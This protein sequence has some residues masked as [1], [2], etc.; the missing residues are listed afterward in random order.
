MDTLFV[1][2]NT[3]KSSRGYTYFQLSVA[4]KGFLYVVPIKKNVKWLRLWINS[5]KKVVHQM[6]LYLM[7]HM[8]KN[9]K[10]E[11]NNKW[12]RYHPQNIWRGCT[13]W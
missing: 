8:N 1:A 2:K 6:I 11:E 12:D 5:Q 4:N 10:Y 9:I 13:M 7:L 3:G